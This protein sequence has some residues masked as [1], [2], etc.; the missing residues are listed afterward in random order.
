[1]G[2]YRKLENGYEIIG[3]GNTRRPE[4][5]VTLIDSNQNISTDIF[6]S[7]TVVTY[8]AFYEELELSTL[9][10]EITCYN[11]GDTLTISA[12][13]GHNYYL[14]STGEATQTITVADTGIYVVWVDQGIGM[15]GSSPYI[16]E[17]ISSHCQPNSIDD[18]L[19]IPAT[20]GTFVGYFDLL[21]R[22]IRQIPTSTI[23]LE[24]YSDGSC[25][26]KILIE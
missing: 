7:D 6:F 2:S 15:L 13:S 5:S 26:K 12:P 8:R 20:E 19:M 10:P 4:P 22:K 17:D 16:I 23:Y 25:I 18:Q 3:W 11:D 9:R 1:M 24:R 14:W 21:G